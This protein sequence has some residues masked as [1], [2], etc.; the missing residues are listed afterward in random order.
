[1][2]LSDLQK[3]ILSRC[4]LNDGNGAKADFYGFYSKKKLGENK[5][6][7]EDIIHNSLESLVAKDLLVAFGRK[8][9]QKWFINKV[10]LTA[11]GRRT[12]KEIIRERQAKLPIK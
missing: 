10:K 3:Y 2:R 1:M 9:A 5:R 8:T 4:R 12:A 6:N 11:E 7:I